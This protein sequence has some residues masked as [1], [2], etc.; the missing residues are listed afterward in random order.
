MEIHRNLQKIY[1]SPLEGWNTTIIQ[2][3]T[4][5][6]IHIVGLLTKGESSYTISPSLTEGWR[7][8]VCTVVSLK[9][10][11]NILQLVRKYTD[12]NKNI[13]QEDFFVHHPASLKM[14]SNKWNSIQRQYF[15]GVNIN[16]KGL[17][18]HPGLQIIQVLYFS[19]SF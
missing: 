14:N 4:V 3:N 16:Y 1:I 6:T 5:E 7:V 13:A 12:M 15:V 11:Q 2:K 8:R 19:F 18:I 17:G 9:L 10:N